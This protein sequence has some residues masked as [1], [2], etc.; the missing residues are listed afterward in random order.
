MTYDERIIKER[1]GV[2]ESIT[3]DFSFLSDYYIDILR[4]NIIKELT[5]MK[6]RFDYDLFHYWKSAPATNPTKIQMVNWYQA[7]DQ[8]INQIVFNLNNKPIT[9]ELYQLSPGQNHDVRRLFYYQVNYIHKCIQED[10]RYSDEEEKPIFKTMQNHLSA[11]AGKINTLYYWGPEY[12]H[13]V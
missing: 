10:I 9:F 1:R 7:L 2:L 11:M 5:D 4:K 3:V 12:G 6:L 13:S 8:L